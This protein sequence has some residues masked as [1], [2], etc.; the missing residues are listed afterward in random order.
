MKKS[1]SQDPYVQIEEGDSTPASS[2]WVF[3]A[4][5]PNF[6]DEILTLPLS[7]AIAGVFPRPA[8]WAQGSDGFPRFCYVYH[9]HLHM[10]D[11]RLAVS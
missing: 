3:S 6:A 7:L 11:G 9:H 4:L 5:L 8:H 10:L 2:T 1:A